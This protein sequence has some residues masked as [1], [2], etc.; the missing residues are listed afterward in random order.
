MTLRDQWDR[1]DAE[2]P[3]WLLDNPGRALVPRT[4]TTRI[5]K[6]PAKHVEVD[7]HGQM[8][9]SP[10]DRDFP[11]RKRNGHGCGPNHR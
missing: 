8:I 4:L 2:T 10:E 5:Q 7:G 6:N 9:L 11:P 1:L 3:R